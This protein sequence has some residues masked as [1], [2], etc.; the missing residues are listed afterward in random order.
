[1]RAPF[2]FPVQFFIPMPSTLG[3]DKKEWTENFF[4]LF[5]G[6][7][8]GWVGPLYTSWSPYRIGLSSLDFLLASFLYHPVLFASAPWPSFRQPARWSKLDHLKP[9]PLFLKPI[10]AKIFCKI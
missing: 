4:P 10:S 6:G 1:M 9:T 2:L 8:R 3:I 7:W 5:P